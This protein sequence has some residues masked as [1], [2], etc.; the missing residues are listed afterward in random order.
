MFKY[1]ICIIV[2]A[3]LLACSSANRIST[4]AEQIPVSDV[5]DNQNKIDSIVSPYK[6]ELEAEMLEIIAVSQHDFTKGRPNGSLNNWAADVTLQSQ[7]RN[8]ALNAPAFCLLNVGGLRSPIGKGNVSLGDIYKLMP[9]D[10]EIVLVEMPIASLKDIEAYLKQSGGEP[11]AGASIKGGSLIVDGMDDET[12]TFWII[13]SDYLMNGGDRM[14]FFNQKL[15]NIYPGILL[16][17]VFIAEAKTQ[18]TLV[19]DNENRIIF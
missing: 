9:F 12:K 15:S 13:T 6:V 16:R 1:F 19:W 5:Y 7:I 2:G 17:D 11:I 8:A 3:G 10:N 4:E 18:G 14:D